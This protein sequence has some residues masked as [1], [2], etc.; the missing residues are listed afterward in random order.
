MYWSP[1]NIQYFSNNNGLAFYSAG[2]FESDCVGK[3]LIIKTMH[4]T[5]HTMSW[6]MW[7]NLPVSL[8]FMWRGAWVRG[9]A[10]TRTKLCVT[11]RCTGLLHLCSHTLHV[12]TSFSS[13]HWVAFWWL[14]EVVINHSQLNW[15]TDILYHFHGSLIRAEWLHTF[16]NSH[17]VSWVWQS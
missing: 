9:Y 15:W 12:V 1:S 13:W 17:L 5:T 6:E 4:Q 14:H 16:K 2:H 10:R 11:L 7:S 8:P 3:N